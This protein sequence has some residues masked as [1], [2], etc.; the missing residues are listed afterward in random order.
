[1]STDLHVQNLMLRAPLR[2]SWGGGI[3]PPTAVGLV[4]FVSLTWTQWSGNCV[5]LYFFLKVEMLS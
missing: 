2:I 3:S 5:T 1:M 4:Q